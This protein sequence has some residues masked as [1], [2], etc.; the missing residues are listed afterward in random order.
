MKNSDIINLATVQSADPR[1]TYLSANLR[2]IRDYDIQK[3]VRDN[4]P[5]LIAEAKKITESIAA[6]FGTGWRWNDPKVIEILDRESDIK[7][8]KVKITEDKLRQLNPNWDVLYC[9][10]FIATIK[11]S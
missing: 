10:D 3:C 9:F 11:K 1:F 5:I 7:L 2:H 4:E 6:T 8:S